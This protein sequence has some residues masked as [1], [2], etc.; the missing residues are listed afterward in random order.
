MLI[1]NELE[2][3]IFFK[4]RLIHQLITKKVY[5]EQLLFAKHFY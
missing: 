4:K 2:R 1:I 3:W 5:F